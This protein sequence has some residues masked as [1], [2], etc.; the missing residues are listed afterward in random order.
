MTDD[1]Q[2][3][4]VEDAADILQVTPRQAHRYGGGDHPR[5][6]TR[7]AGRRIL[8]HRGDVEA[9]AVDLGVEFRSRSKPP[10]PQALAA[11]EL[12][13]YIEQL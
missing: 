11:S 5:I 12:L 1:T 13:A 4:T 3:I 6:R 10:A 9:L 8:Y 2:Y 7:K